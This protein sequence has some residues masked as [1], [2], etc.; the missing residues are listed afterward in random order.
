MN[1]ATFE[2]TANAR[3]LAAGFSGIPPQAAILKIAA[4]LHE[5]ELKK[6]RITAGD[7][8]SAREAVTTLLDAWEA[9]A[10]TVDDETAVKRMATAVEM[11]KILTK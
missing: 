4:S 9:I 10:Y 1:A 11:A 5:E 8:A 6:A 3:V 2:F 7:V